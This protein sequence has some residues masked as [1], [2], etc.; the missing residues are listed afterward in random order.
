MVGKRNEEGGR[1]D[2][3]DAMLHLFVFPV[4]TQLLQDAIPGLH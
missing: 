2:L 4:I 1:A 3:R